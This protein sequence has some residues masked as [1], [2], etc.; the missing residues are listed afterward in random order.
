MHAGRR[1]I[2]G[3]AAGGSSERVVWLA[4][5]LRRAGFDCVESSDFRCD[6]WIKLWG[7]LST[8][9]ISLL[10]AATLDR[11]IDEPL[12]HTLCVRMMEEAKRIGEAIDIPRHRCCRTSSTASL[13]RSTRC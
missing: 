12:V 11:I 2:I 9:P 7:N 13:S 5:W 4:E 3:A 6:I 10:T 1:L 8:N